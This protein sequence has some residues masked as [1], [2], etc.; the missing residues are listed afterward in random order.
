MNA[1][2]R[3]VGLKSGFVVTLVSQINFG[4]IVVLKFVVKGAMRTGASNT[5]MWLFSSLSKN[6]RR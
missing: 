4:N 6:G 2:A 1:A 3:T 5:G